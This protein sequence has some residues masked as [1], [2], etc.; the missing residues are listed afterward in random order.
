[1]DAKLTTPPRTLLDRIKIAAGG[2]LVGSAFLFPE[3]NLGPQWLR[4][5]TLVIF[6]VCALA[7]GALNHAAFAE[8]PIPAM[9]ILVVLCTAIVAGGTTRNEL[10]PFLPFFLATLCVVT[11]IGPDAWQGLRRPQGASPSEDEHS[12]ASN[13]CCCSRSDRTFSPEPDSEPLMESEWQDHLALDRY[14]SRPLSRLSG[15]SDTEISDISLSGPAPRFRYSRTQ[16]F[17]DHDF[18]SPG[19]DARGEPQARGHAISDGTAS[20]QE[21]PSM[22]ARSDEGT[23]ESSFPLLNPRGRGL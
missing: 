18:P 6:A 8:F 1:M 17:F 7:F 12:A 5:L 21:E 13:R 4:V 3:A 15:R 23:V 20:P 10:I 22:D 16:G 19:Q 14:D 2:G 9:V 11:V